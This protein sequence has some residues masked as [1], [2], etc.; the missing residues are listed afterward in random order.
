MVGPDGEIDLALDRLGLARLSTAGRYVRHVGNVVTEDLAPELS[1]LGLAV[2]VTPPSRLAVAIR[3]RVMAA[4]RRV[5]NWCYFARHY[6]PL[7]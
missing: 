1:A 6:R 7:R 2:D 3:T 5:R 4:L